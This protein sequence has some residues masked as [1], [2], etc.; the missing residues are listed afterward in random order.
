[1][2]AEMRSEIWDIY[3]E[4]IR[5]HAHQLLF[6]GYQDAR[7]RIQTAED[8]PEIT[9]L[10]GD[11]M[12]ARLDHPDTPDEFDYYVIGDQ[13]P[14]SPNGEMGNKRKKLDL[15]VIRSVV[16]PRL[17]YVFEA[18]RLMT[19]RYTIGDY[20]GASGM[21]DFIDC[22]YAQGCPEAAMVGLFHNK[23]LSYWHGEL[24]RAYCEDAASAAPQLGVLAHP[25]PITVLADLPGELES[26]HHRTDKSVIVLLHIF[27]DCT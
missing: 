17:S 2:N 22:R 26:R 27:L 11:A 9:G 14:V 20:V 6:W 4:A 12:K 10:L 19:T 15:S 7:G 5:R 21:G 16:K 25:S 8:E 1:M 18:K 3:L 23:G 13:V 24:R